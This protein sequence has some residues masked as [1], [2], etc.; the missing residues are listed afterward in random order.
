MNDWEVGLSTCRGEGCDALEAL[1]DVCDGRGD[2]QAV[3]DPLATQL[4]KAWA[5]VSAL[6]DNVQ[7]IFQAFGSR[8][9]GSAARFQ[10]IAA[11]LWD[12]FGD[13]VKAAQVRDGDFGQLEMGPGELERKIRLAAGDARRIRVTGTTAATASTPPATVESV[14]EMIRRAASP[15]G[16]RVKVGIVDP[17]SMSGPQV[18]PVPPAYYDPK[19]LGGEPTITLT[20][21]KSRFK[22][23]APASVP[24]EVADINRAEGEPQEPAAD[25][26]SGPP[27][28]ALR[29]NAFRC[30]VPDL[31]TRTLEHEAVVSGAAE[32]EPV[33]VRTATEAMQ[34]LGESV[35][36][37]DRGRALGFW[38][39]NHRGLRAWRWVIPDRYWTGG[40]SHY[41]DVF[42]GLFLD[43]FD[44]DRN[45]NRSFL[46]DR[47]EGPFVT[48]EP[49]DLPVGPTVDEQERL[50]ELRAEGHTDHCASAQVA[51]GQECGC[52]PEVEWVP[53]TKSH[54]DLA[55]EEWVGKLTPE[56]PIGV[57]QVWIAKENP[58]PTG[59]AA[60]HP[61]SRIIVKAGPDERGRYGVVPQ[62]DPDRPTLLWVT[63]ESLRSSMRLRVGGL[64][65]GPADTLLPAD[66]IPEP[67]PVRDRLVG[68]VHVSP[69]GRA[70]SVDPGRVEFREP[71]PSDVL[72]R[73]LDDEDATREEN[74][75]VVKAMGHDLAAIEGRL[76]EQIHQ[77]IDRSTWPVDGSRWRWSGS[78]EVP[79][80]S[81]QHLTDG[82]GWRLLADDGMMGE[83]ETGPISDGWE[84]VGD[85]E[86]G[87]ASC[88]GEERDEGAICDE[89]GSVADGRGGHA[90]IVS[91]LMG[92]PIFQ[93]PDGGVSVTID[94][95]GNTTVTVDEVTP[96]G[97][98]AEHL[99]LI[100]SWRM[101][102]PPPSVPSG[103]V[104]SVEPAAV[105]AAVPVDRETRSATVIHTHDPEGKRDPR[106]NPWVGD[107][108]AA[109]VESTAFQIISV[110]EHDV[111]DIAFDAIWL[112]TNERMESVPV[113]NLDDRHYIGHFPPVSDVPPSNFRPAGLLP[114]GW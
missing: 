73:L 67:A 22:S 42:R 85:E 76:N 78:W 90:G 84:P 61:F 32:S 87:C 102:D 46:V 35:V 29:P 86:D 52:P 75:E 92:P 38:Y 49:L 100:E 71:R 54:A 57:G 23:S 59:V 58:E 64:T 56:T 3:A 8:Y 107:R 68:A 72:A 112:D 17:W 74:A 36:S 101:A 1:K 43:A 108:W 30:V 39:T 80:V 103:E 27:S 55:L 81:V 98:Y 63:A 7:S 18:I 89:C 77:A 65:G 110:Y 47:M 15:E 25:F 2:D 93:Q 94:E 66:I 95:A 9:A 83:P 40:I 26:T 4:E 5:R 70:L 44:L 88:D 106:V 48:A 45:A 91:T 31:L 10:Q 11:D 13:E 96:A 79:R 14:T 19:G 104:L 69:D 37:M 53:V 28:L 33:P 60:H 97:P 6:E 114:E 24:L 62:N 111:S 50:A 113:S 21:G 16:P 12:L 109:R 82:T 99:A 20:V 51:A 105:Q 34:R 41:P